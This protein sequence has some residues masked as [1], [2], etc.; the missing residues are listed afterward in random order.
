MS[1][2][3]LRP[4]SHAAY[5]EDYSEDTNTAVPGTRQTANVAAKRSRPELRIKPV[6]SVKGR[7]EASDSGYSSQT[8]ATVASRTSSTPASKTETIPMSPSHLRVQSKNTTIGVQMAGEPRERSPEKPAL[9]RTISRA[10][11]TENLRR[12]STVEGRDAAAKIRLDAVPV[13][14][15][16]SSSRSVVPEQRATARQAG[17]L[18]PQATRAQELPGTQTIPI[19]RPQ[20]AR[21]RPTPAEA[22]RSRPASYHAG[23]GVYLPAQP[24]YAEARPPTLYVNTAQ[25]STPAVTYLPTPPTTSP[26]RQL[27]YPFPP[28]TFPQPYQHPP[29]PQW[30]AIPQDLSSRRSSM[31]SAQAVS[32]YGPILYEAVPVYQYQVPRRMS[33]HRSERPSPNTPLDE[34]FYLDERDEADED[35]YRMPPPALKRSTSRRQPTQRPTIRHANTTS[36]AYVTHEKRQSMYETVDVMPEKSSRK[37]PLEAARPPSRPA[38]ASRPS[39]TS[40]KHA[41][42]SK[43]SAERSPTKESGPAPQ[44]P[45]R[46]SRRPESYGGHGD[47]E[48]QVEAYQDAKSGSERPVPLTAEKINQVVR[49]R[50]KTQA[51]HGS[52]SSS[53][54]SSS[55]DGSDLKNSNAQSRSSAD[56]RRGSSATERPDDGIT[57]SI[58]N[59][60]SGMKLGLKG[61][62]V[63][64]RAIHVRQGQDGD[65]AMEVRIGSRSTV[66]TRDGRPRERSVRRYSYAGSGKGVREVAEDQYVRQRSKS[67]VVEERVLEKE[68]KKEDKAKDE[69][70]LDRLRR[71]TGSSRSRGTSKS[72]VS[73]R[74]LPEGQPF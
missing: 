5:F 60:R 66:S 65:G 22:P 35:F 13:R 56:K 8:A 33:G 11:K 17:P 44:V 18:S 53:R 64:G 23:M 34:S 59:A 48:R 25:Y 73:R 70:M 7:D 55:R 46:R 12:Q 19:P 2:N 24:I 1:S 30:S 14:T 9:Y 15:T 28:A 3:S 27:A 40:L 29:Q 42:S 49:R 16:A 26:Q 67:R 37:L 68:K 61:D 71:L 31:Y 36:A 58:A 6:S 38:A 45:V 72:V 43:Y 57:I 50:S 62:G 52:K 63:E 39:N 54:A 69:D 47:L 10:K 41:Q 32:D 21:P 4:D 74:G 20:Q 51:S